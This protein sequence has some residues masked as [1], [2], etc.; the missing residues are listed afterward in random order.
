M[1]PFLSL[2][3]KY[4]RYQKPVQSVIL[5]VLKRGWFTLG[6]EL[7]S[8]EAAFGKFLGV[9]YTVGVNSGT[10]ALFLALKALDVGLGHEVITV[11]NTAT[12]TVSAIRMAGAVPVF[13]DVL[14]ETLTLN[15]ALLERAITPQTRA[16]IPVHLFG[17][18][19][20]MKEIMRVA[21]RHRLAVVEDAC[22][23]HGAKYG[24]QTVG[25]IGDAGCFSFYPTKN[26][27]GL[28]DGGTVATN[29]PRLAE[30]I[31]ALRNYGEIAKYINRYEGVNSRLDEIQAA[32]LNWG[33][34]HL[35]AWN[36]RRAELAGT[37]LRLLRDAPLELPAMTDSTKRR[38][39]HLFVIRTE[40]RDKLQ[41]DLRKLGI[42]T[43]I[44]YPMPI[45]K[46]RAYQF[47]GCKASDLPVTTH[48]SKRILSLPLYPE[49]SAADVSRVSEAILKF[50][51]R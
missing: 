16:I 33:L 3:E 5:R 15:P 43:A 42:E 22:Q 21:R 32:I 10:D 26:L 7:K 9:K 28:G 27:G 31:S 17:C 46:Q 35:N 12:P 51:G 1:I 24:K 48:A 19:A 4:R 38:V 29:N 45:Y 8:F 47:L 20:E 41:A 23:A 36:Q 30:R 11:A 2:A 44:H 49:L 34:G 6:P 39:W 40:R 37:Y 25:T 14:P 18:P 13:V 50:H